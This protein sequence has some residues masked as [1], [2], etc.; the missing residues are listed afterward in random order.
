MPWSAIFFLL[1]LIKTSK[2]PPK[3]AFSNSSTALSN[4]QVQVLQSHQ[5]YPRASLIAFSP[6]SRILFLFLFPNHWVI[7]D[8]TVRRLKIDLLKCWQARVHWTYK[9]RAGCCDATPRLIGRFL[10]SSFDFLLSV[11]FEVIINTV[12]RSIRHIH[13][14]DS[15]LSCV[16][17]IKCDFMN[18]LAFNSHISLIADGN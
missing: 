13:G 9:R 14:P 15:W 7:S 8:S 1:S 3:I 12:V 10:L 6:S 16:W 17:Q 2:E 4:T 5:S 11:S 18:I